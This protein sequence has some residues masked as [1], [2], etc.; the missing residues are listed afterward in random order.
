VTRVNRGSPEPGRWLFV[1]VLGS[2]IVFATLVAVLA[3][4]L[5]PDPGTQVAAI[6]AAVQALSAVVI[7]VLTVWLALT[8]ANA[9]DAARAEARAAGDAI[10][11]MRRQRSESRRQAQLEAIPILSVSAPEVWS[12]RR[13]TLRV[14]LRNATNVPALD[15]KLGFY[16]EGGHEYVATRYPVL[17]VAEEQALTI[18]AE[19][20]RNMGLTEET[21]RAAIDR[22][23]MPP[24]LAADRLMVLVEV[25]SALGAQVTQRYRWLANDPEPGRPTVWR[26][27]EVTIVPDPDNPTDQVGLTQATLG[28]S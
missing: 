5:P 12:T 14:L 23:H 22:G 4:V 15:I 9:L 13:L 3:L 21:T 7:V 8:A 10:E 28:G 11:E 17:G 6:S 1:G 20:L 26:L 27:V 16:G 19:D 2:A 25:R 18:P 24:Y